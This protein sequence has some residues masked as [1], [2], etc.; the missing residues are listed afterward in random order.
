[1]WKNRDLRHSIESIKV[2]Q[3]F[4]SSNIGIRSLQLRNPT[5]MLYL[6]L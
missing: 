5:P 3:L 2:I 4:N 6:T 1:M